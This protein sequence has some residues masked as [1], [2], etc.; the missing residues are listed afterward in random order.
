MHNSTAYRPL[1]SEFKYLTVVVLVYCT[2]RD[3]I[4]TQC[5]SFVF[6]FLLSFLRPASVHSQK[7]R[8]S[9]QS[10]SSSL[11]SIGMFLDHVRMYLCSR[12][13]TCDLL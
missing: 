6:V 12:L 2:V 7:S 5:C 9:R 1:L 10:S 3:H 8:Q 13:L 4:E 11:S